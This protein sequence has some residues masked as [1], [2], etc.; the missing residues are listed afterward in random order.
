[1]PHPRRAL[2]A[3]LLAAAG[4]ARANGTEAERI[5]RLV[6]AY[7]DHLAGVEGDLL[8]WRDG[9]RMLIGAGLPERSFEAMLHDATIADQMRQPY[10][11]GPPDGPPPRDFSPGRI[12]STAF[13]TRMYG[14]CRAGGVPTRGAAWLGRQ[15]L[16]MTTVNGVADRLERVAASLEG[17]PDRFRAYLVPSAGTLSCRGVADTGLVSMHAFGAAIDINTRHS[18]YWHWARARGD[19]EIPYRNRIPFEIVEAFEVERF[20]WG[21]KWYHYDTMHFEYRPELFG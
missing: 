5:A 15:T 16:A 21:G 12:R 9:A 6:R 18:D 8:V 20:I 19:G 2:L 3:G 11:P 7:P 14:E 4:T 10:R 13:F 1:M 17:M